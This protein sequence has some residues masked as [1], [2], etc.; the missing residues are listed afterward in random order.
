MRVEQAGHKEG[1]D[2]ELGNDTDQIMYTY[3]YDMS[4]ISMYNYNAPIKYNLKLN[5]F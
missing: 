4:P 3:K 5:F 1:R 2:R